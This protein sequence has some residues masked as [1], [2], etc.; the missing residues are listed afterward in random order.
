MV[1]KKLCLKRQIYELIYTENHSH[2]NISNF[3][4]KYQKKKIKPG[5][6]YHRIKKTRRKQKKYLLEKPV[7]TNGCICREGPV[8]WPQNSR[9]TRKSRFSATF[10]IFHYKFHILLIEANFKYSGISSWTTKFSGK[11]I[12]VLIEEKL[13]NSWVNQDLS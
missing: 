9:T 8:P 7:H 5:V 1:Y 3:I 6:S 11:K 4:N 12:I 10:C 13:K 2:F